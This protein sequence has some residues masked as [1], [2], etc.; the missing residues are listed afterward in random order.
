VNFINCT[1]ED[2]S[3]EILAILN[4]SILNSTALYDYKARSLASMVDWFDTKQQANLPVLGV[5]NLSNELMGFATYGS[6][7]AWPANKYSVEHSVYIHPDH[8]G[9]GL[10]FMLMQRLIARAL[11]QQYHT[12]IAGIDVS[13]PASI[14]LH[15]KLGFSHA[16][17]IKHAGFK[18]GRWLDLGFYQLLLDTPEQ[19][20]DG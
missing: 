14:H 7:R 9:Q 12:M 11:Q 17:T 6:F 3:H 15:Q 10:A 4:D 13:N 5:T 19:P 18:F 20:C 8:R 16:G 2:H 1:H